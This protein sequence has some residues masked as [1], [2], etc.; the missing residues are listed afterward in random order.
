MKEIYK[1]GLKALN[2]FILNVFPY[3]IIL[4][5]SFSIAIITENPK[6]IYLIIVSFIML[7]VRFLYHLYE[8]GK[9]ADEYKKERKNENS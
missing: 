9:L 2:K 3:A 6:T 1:L 7:I 8:I 4:V 5:M